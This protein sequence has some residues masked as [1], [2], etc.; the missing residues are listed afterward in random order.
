M[1]KDYTVTDIIYDT[2]GEDIDLPT[3]L[4]ISVPDDI[5][6]DLILTDEILD[7]LSD[8]ISNKTDFCHKGFK[9]VLDDE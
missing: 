7:Y 6:G 3:T 4:V 5:L 9:V 2:D 1:A 8:E